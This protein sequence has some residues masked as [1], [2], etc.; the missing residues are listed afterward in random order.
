MRHKLSEKKKKRTTDKRVT[1]LHKN[2]ESKEKIG[3]ILIVNECF[4][5]DILMTNY[6]FCFVF[7]KKKKLQYH[8]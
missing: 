5:N 8:A 3:K 4:K 6:T 2:C 7:K 1:I